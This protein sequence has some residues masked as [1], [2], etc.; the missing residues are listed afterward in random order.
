M[1]GA[2]RLVL[3]RGSEDDV[4]VRVGERAVLEEFG[5]QVIEFFERLDE[6]DVLAEDKKRDGARESMLSGVRAP[7]SPSSRPGAP[8]SSACAWRVSRRPTPF[9]SER[10]P[11]PP[12]CLSHFTM[13]YRAGFPPV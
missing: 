1:D 6:R 11:S 2:I 3:G 8:A 10:L 9:D 13:R 4:E 12:G 5:G 7:R